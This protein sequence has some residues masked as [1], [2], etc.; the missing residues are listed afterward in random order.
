MSSCNFQFRQFF[1]AM[2]TPIISAATDPRNSGMANIYPKTTAAPS[3]ISNNIS[4]KKAAKITKK[5]RCM[6]IKQQ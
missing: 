3:L 5:K 2:E 4:T 1:I 6:K